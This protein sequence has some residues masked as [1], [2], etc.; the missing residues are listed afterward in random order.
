MDGISKII[1]RKRRN[2]VQKCKGEVSD[3]RLV[4]ELG[5]NSQKKITIS[6]IINRKC[7]NSIQK[8]RVESSDGRLVAELGGDSRKSERCRKSFIESVGFPIRNARANCRM[9]GWSRNGVV[10]LEKHNDFKNN[11]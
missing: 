1:D 10:N 8:F 5:G 9:D 3:G 7:R 11:G 6:T 4:P 2:S